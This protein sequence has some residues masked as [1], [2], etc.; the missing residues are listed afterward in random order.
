[1]SGYLIFRS[2]IFLPISNI[3]IIAFEKDICQILAIYEYFC[4]ISG[5]EPCGL[6]LLFFVSLVGISHIVSKVAG[7]HP[8]DHIPVFWLIRRCP[9]IWK[10]PIDTVHPAGIFSAVQLIELVNSFHIVA[11]IEWRVFRRNL[12][13]LFPHR[14]FLKISK[15]LSPVV[16]ETVVFLGSVHPPGQT[17]FGFL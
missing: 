6:T 12:N 4:M 14:W 8:Q 3:S 9:I 11:V 10:C 16:N 2:L 5:L 1:M 15:T 7:V 13:P 17:L